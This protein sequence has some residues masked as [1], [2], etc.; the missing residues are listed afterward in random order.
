MMSYCNAEFFYCFNDNEE[1]G[2]WKIEI[3]YLIVFSYWRTKM[4]LILYVLLIVY[5]VVAG[6]QLYLITRA[7]LTDIAGRVDRQRL[8]FLTFIYFSIILHLSAISHTLMYF[9]LWGWFCRTFR[10]HKFSIYHDEVHWK[11]R[12]GVFKQDLWK[13]SVVSFFIDCYTVHFFRA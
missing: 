2:A 10:A 6:S 8:F 1:Q 11:W 5:F 3:M 12:K 9:M 7:S 4:L 13:R